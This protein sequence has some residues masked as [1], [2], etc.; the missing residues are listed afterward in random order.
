[1]EARKSQFMKIYLTKIPKYQKD[2][3]GFIE[4]LNNM[5]KYEKKSFYKHC[6]KSYANFITYT[7]GTKWMQFFDF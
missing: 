2:A 3:A 7:K 1:M 5:V 4:F 6:S